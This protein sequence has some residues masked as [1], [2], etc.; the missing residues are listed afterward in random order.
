MNVPFSECIPIPLK[1]SIQTILKSN[2]CLIN[3]NSYS[4]IKKKK[5]LQT[6]LF[7]TTCIV[8]KICKNSLFKS[9]VLIITNSNIDAY[10]NKHYNKS[11]NWGIC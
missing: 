10:P 6:Q 8:L 2:L 3:V 11:G 4:I 7:R 9:L 1:E 5:I